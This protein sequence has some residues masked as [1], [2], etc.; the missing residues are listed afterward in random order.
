MDLQI[1][2]IHFDADQKLKQ[3]TEKKVGKLE[4]FYNKIVNAEVFLKL[5]NDGSSVRN[6][7][8]EVRLQVPGATLFAAEKSKVFEESIDLAINSLRK[9]L[10][11]HKEKFKK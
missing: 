4:T 5:E 2:T 11:R 9:Q 6:K 3:F 10:S 1:Q 7:I 8:A